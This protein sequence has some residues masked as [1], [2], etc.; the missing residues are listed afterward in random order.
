MRVMECV[1]CAIAK[2]ALSALVPRYVMLLVTEPGQPNS[3]TREFVR[4]DI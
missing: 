4:L 3:L 1:V 2:S